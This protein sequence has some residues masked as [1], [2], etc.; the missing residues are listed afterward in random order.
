VTLPVQGNTKQIRFKDEL[1][2]VENGNIGNGKGSM[3]P[4]MDGYQGEVI[5]CENPVNY[6][7]CHGY[8]IP[9]CF[10]DRIIMALKWKQQRSMT[11][12][13]IEHSSVRT[14]VENR[15]EMESGILE[16]RYNL[17]LRSGHEMQKSGVEVKSGISEWI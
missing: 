6:L 1:D 10:Q 4:E 16:R 15:V 8:D 2:G 12:V 11:K 7:F 14:N 9:V 13:E 5:G 3:G 17:E